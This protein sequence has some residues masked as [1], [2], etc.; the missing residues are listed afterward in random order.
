MKV[1]IPYDPRP[2]QLAIHEQ[3]AR[4]RRGVIVCHRRFGKTVCAVNHLQT[5]AIACRKQRPRFGYLSPTYAQ[6]K[7]IAWDYMKHY[8]RPIPG[9]Q[10]N[11]SELTITYPGG[12]KVRIYGADNPDSLRG[13]YFDGV[14]LDEF[15]LMRPETLPEVIGPTLIDRQGWCLVMG[16]PQGKNHL[17]YELE[18]V[19]QDPAACTA[20]YR[21]SESGVLP[22]E[23]LAAER[24]RMTEDEYQREY[25]CSFEASVRGAIYAREMERMRLEGRLT[26]VPY[27]PALPVETN[28]DLGYRDATAIWFSQSAYGGQIRLIAYYQASGEALDHYLRYVQQQPYTYGGHWFP[29]DI[30]QH[31]FGTGKRLIDTAR[32]MLRDVQ[33]APATAVRD[34]IHAVRLMLSRTWMD[35]DRCQRG[36]DALT[37]YRWHYNTELKEYTNR[38][39]HDWA[40]HGADALRVLAVRDDPLRR[41][42][43]RQARRDDGEAQHLAML[44]RE[45]GWRPPRPGSLRRGGYT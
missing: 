2:G 9:I 16:T 35:L 21:A 30:E 22:E 45:Y 38:P 36:W 5:A 28:W 12:A 40:S 7:A 29:H 8:A 43:T 33:V 20:V 44:R 13:L 23:E 42:E 32:A 1:V 3:M 31:E 10:V 19:R 27:D 4:C 41:R 18:R 6:G 26:Q 15:G 34:G 17:Y 24:A 39:E 25:E 14:V 37:S 11:E